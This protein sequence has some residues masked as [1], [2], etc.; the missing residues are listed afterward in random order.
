MHSFY[1]DTVEIKE[2][3]SRADIND[4]NYPSEWQNN[5]NYYKSFKITDAD[6]HSGNGSFVTTAK[7]AFMRLNFN[8]KAI[9]VSNGTVYLMSFWYKAS[10]GTP[11]ISFVTADAEN[12]SSGAVKQASYKTAKSDKGKWKKAYVLF[13]AAPQGSNNTLWL[14]V[15]GADKL[16]IDDIKLTTS[17]EIVFN[18]MGGTMNGTEICTVLG[19]PGATAS[20]SAPVKDGMYFY[21]WYQDAAL[22]K[23]CGALT[24]PSDS[25]SITVYAKWVDSLPAA[26][27]DF[28]D[29]PYGS[30]NSKWGSNTSTFFSPTVAEIITED[31]RFAK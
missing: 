16:N 8:D 5:A 14:S 10:S 26:I 3:C 24:F 30:D 1:I 22:T 17:T 6:A 15:S 11:E 21:G 23:K 29:A 13:T 7:N 31:M 12:A 19:T 28:E 20:Y 9:R 27:V 2:V 25:D 4:E 18:T